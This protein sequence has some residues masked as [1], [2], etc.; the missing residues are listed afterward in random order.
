MQNPENKYGGC[1]FKNVTA[2]Q[3]HAGMDY[4][5]YIP[6]SWCTLILIHTDV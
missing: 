1:S 3:P 6:T 4:M 5:E 2:E